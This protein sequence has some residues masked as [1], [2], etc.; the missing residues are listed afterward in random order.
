MGVGNTYIKD[1]PWNPN[2]ARNSSAP[3]KPYFQSLRLFF[4]FKILTLVL[5]CNLPFPLTQ[6]HHPSCC[7]TMASRQYLAL[8]SMPRSS[9]LLGP[10]CQDVRMMF[11]F[12][13]T[14]AQLILTIFHAKNSIVSLISTNEGADFLKI[15]QVSLLLSI[16]FTIQAVKSGL[17]VHPSVINVFHASEES[18]G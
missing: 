4:A 3:N 17:S 8:A 2:P 11:H 16:N 1:E 15:S 7:P 6:G 9:M 14:S 5:W 18:H 12:L 13:S 10:N